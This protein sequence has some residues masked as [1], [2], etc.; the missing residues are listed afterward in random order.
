MVTIRDPILCLHPQAE[1]ARRAKL[2]ELHRQLSDATAANAKRAARLATARQTQDRLAAERSSAADARELAA[3]KV[4]ALRAL[5]GE[6]IPDEE[7]RARLAAEAEEAMEKV[8]ILRLTMNNISRQNIIRADL[9]RR[10]D[11]GRGAAGA[12]AE[13]ME[14]V[15]DGTI[16]HTHIHI[17]T[18]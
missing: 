1:S 15:R 4:S 16:T 10:G 14:K 18:Y 11:F 17:Q 5:G 7:R 12:A 6:A 8:N 3:A 13:A 2:G 9:Q